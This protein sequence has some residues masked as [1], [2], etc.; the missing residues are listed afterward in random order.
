M[1]FFK[2]FGRLKKITLNLLILISLLIHFVFHILETFSQPANKSAGDDYKSELSVYAI[3]EGEK[4][5][6]YKSEFAIGIDCY[7]TGKQIKENAPVGIESNP[8]EH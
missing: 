1:K 4:C 2:R 7:L 5:V 8:G 6:I 3:D